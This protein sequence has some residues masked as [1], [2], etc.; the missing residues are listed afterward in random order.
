MISYHGK[1]VAA[2]KVHCSSWLVDSGWWWVEKTCP[3]RQAANGRPCH[4]LKTMFCPAAVL[5]SQRKG[6]ST[7][8]RIARLRGSTNNHQPTTSVGAAD[9]RPATNVGAANHNPQ[10][11]RVSPTPSNPSALAFPSD[12]H[13]A[14]VHNHR[15]PA[16]AFRI[17]QH[18]L[19][20]IAGC[21]NVDVIHL[22][23]LLLEGFTGLRGVGS[24]VFAE[25]QYFGRHG[26]PP[27]HG[28]QKVRVIG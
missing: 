12:G 8:F 28:I 16:L 5:R 18:A 2:G 4:L 21:Q 19:E 13:I 23:F 6:I 17:F 22:F 1:D 27:F 25:N 26:Q 3:F 24:G 15:D 9:H 7:R 20:L 10:R 11:P 14:S